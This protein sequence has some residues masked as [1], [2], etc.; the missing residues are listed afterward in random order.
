M[1]VLVNILRKLLF[2]CGEYMADVL[3]KEQRRTNMMHIRASDTKAEIVLRKQ[4]WKLGYRYRKN[5]N[6]LP[7]TPDLAFSKYKIAVFVDGEFWHGKGFYGNYESKKFSSLKEQLE[8][9]SNSKFW[10]EKITRNMERDKE[11]DAQL[12]AMGWKVIRLW[13]KDVLKHTEL[14]VKTIEEA[15][16]DSFISDV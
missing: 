5:Y 3:T 10:I 1:I 9:S 16:F 15:I 11:V 8:H 13:S 14:S 12:I 6:R 2:R 4:L 7:G